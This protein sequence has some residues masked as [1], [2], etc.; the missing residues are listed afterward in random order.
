M[1]VRTLS[2]RLDPR[3]HLAA[4][5]GWAVFAVVTLAGLIAAHLAA[6][7]AEHR[8]RRDAEGL[9]AEF[10]T[11]VRDALSMNLESR[12]SVLQATAAQILASGPGHP[13]D[14]ERRFS[15]MQARFPEFAWLGAVDGSGRVRVGTGRV[16]VGADVSGTPWFIEGRQRPFVGERYLAVSPVVPGRSGQGPGGPASLDFAVPLDPTRPV[17]S[18]VVAAHVDWHWVERMLSRMQDA[19]SRRRQIEIMLASRDGTVLVGPSTWLGV[20]PAGDLDLTEGGAYSIGTRTQLRLADGLGLGW[21]AVVRQRTDI[22]FETVRTTRRTVFSTVF[23][24]GLLAAGCAAMVARV[25]TRRLSLLARDAEAVRSGQARA[26]TP[27]AGSDEV[28]RIGGTLAQLVDHLQAEKQALQTLNSELDRRVAE[29]TLRIERMG[30]EARH[31]AV[32]RE[33]LRIA[34]DLHDTLAH[35]MMALLTQVRLVRKLRHRMTPAELDAELDRAENVA[36]SGLSEA[37]AAITRMRD[38]GVHD[39]GLGPAL[40]D[41]AR[42]F[43]HRT[44]LPCRLDADPGMAAWADDRAETVFRIVE[45]ALRNVERHARANAVRISLRR[46]GQGGAPASDEGECVLVDVV[47]D[48]IG[49]DTTRPRPGHYGLRGMQEQAALISARC[50]ILSEPGKGTR[51]TLRMVD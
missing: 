33:R 17:R 6:A 16:P 5:I 34:R 32:T 50:E 27:P 12:R 24:A 8:A 1:K 38:N 47:D 40:G 22:A 37:R 48:G 42:H 43:E 10:A 46:D 20:R 35:S 13:T 28:S 18:G 9:L 31:A 26:L 41:L 7:Q 15:A 2:M 39:T 30:D 49:F 29:R 51:L 4:A 11:Q 23:L 45:E 36:A 21:T 25:F 14:V 44:G 19:L 3:L